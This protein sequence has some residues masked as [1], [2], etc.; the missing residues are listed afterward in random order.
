MIIVSVVIPN[1]RVLVRC[2][3]GVEYEVGYRGIREGRTKR[4]RSCTGKLS[5]KK[6]HGFR[7]NGKRESLYVKWIGLKGRCSNKNNKDYKRLGG[8]N[9]LLDSKWNDYATFRD[10]AYHSGYEEGDNLFRLDKNN[11]HTPS[12]CFWGK[13][14]PE[15]KYKFRD[16]FDTLSSLH[17]R[18]RSNVPIKLVQNRLSRGWELTEALLR[19]LGAKV[20]KRR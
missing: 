3:C 17:K 4:C 10:W 12:N 7:S 1:K 2:D 13:K 8:R 9:I 20:K 16:E 6:K 19:P 15:K 5:V 14:R 11:N 18:L